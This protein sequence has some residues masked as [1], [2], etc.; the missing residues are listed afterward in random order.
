MKTYGYD[1]SYAITIDEVNKI[2]ASNLASVNMKISYSCVDPD[3]GTTITIQGQ[4][5]PWQLNSKGDNNLLGMNVPI[6]QGSM[7]LTGG[8]LT[9]NYDLSGV[10]AVMKISLSWMG[11]GTAQSAQGSGDM[12]SLVFAPV[13]TTDP[14]N[15]GYVTTDNLLDPQKKLDDFASGLLQKCMA[16]VIVENKDNL[17]LIFNSINP[18]PANVASWLKPYKWQYFYQQT[19]VASVFCLLCQLTDKDFPSG[20]SFDSSALSSSA[21]SS[22]LISQEVFFANAIL[23]SIQSAL[24]SGNFSLNTSNE[25]CSITNNGD[26]N[27][28]TSNGEITAHSFNLSTSSS[29]NGLAC[30]TSGGGPLDFFFGLGKLPDASYSWSLSTV[31]PLSFADNTIRFQDDPNPAIQQNSTIHWYD[32]ALLVVTGITN[33]A[34]LVSTIMDSINGFANQVQAVG[35][36]NVN[37]SIESSITGSVVNLA[38]LIDWKQSQQTFQAVDAGLNGALYTYGNQV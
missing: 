26:F 29:G 37:N 28:S 3:T 8:I 2:L 38:N 10:T 17:K 12:T 27:I 30:H 25:V 16:D 34:G 23:P 33:V 35:M 6:S 5:A 4:L 15:P 13:S 21:N 18:A 32:W 31:N 9:G 24:G 11:S 7:S 20:P 36:G 1:Y 22:I 19:S 14:D